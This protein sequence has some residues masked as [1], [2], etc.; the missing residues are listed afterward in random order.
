MLRNNEMKKH[1]V[2]SIIILFAFFINCDSHSKWSPD[3]ITA[4]GNV[5]DTVYIWCGA[6]P[7]EKKY[8]YRTG[9]WEFRNKKGALFAAGEYDVYVKKIWDHGA[10]EYEYLE[11]SID[12]KKWQFWNLQGDKIEPTE[13]EITL[14]NFKV[15]NED[16]INKGLTPGY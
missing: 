12:L 3:D 7:T 4:I 11:N 2:I 10:C 8:S 1:L 13:Y 14:V 5:I 16:S 6:V 15:K 9:K